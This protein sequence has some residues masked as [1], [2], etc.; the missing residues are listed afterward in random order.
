ML[1]FKNVGILIKRNSK[2]ICSYHTLR[3]RTFR[4]RHKA[5]RTRCAQA[6]KRPRDFLRSGYLS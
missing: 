3:A 2:I 4:V 5:L 1:K 6:Y